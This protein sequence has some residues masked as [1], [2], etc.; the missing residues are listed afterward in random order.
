MSKSVIEN[1][2]KK[3]IDRKAMIKNGFN[4][5][6][7]D[8]VLRGKSSYKLEDII[9]ISE[10]FQLSLDYLICGSEKAAPQ[11]SEEEQ[12]ILEVYNKLSE[13]NKLLALGY[14]QGLNDANR[15]ANSNV[16]NDMAEMLPNKTDFI[17]TSAIENI[18]TK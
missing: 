2:A 14:I 17:Q 3:N 13:R 15:K 7:F 1:L 9:E 8:D 6:K 10:K 18:D 4:P 5:Q 11:I 16:A 12:E